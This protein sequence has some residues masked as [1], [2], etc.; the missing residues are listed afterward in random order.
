MSEPV[1][2]TISIE[3]KDVL[4]TY[5]IFYGPRLR[6]SAE[7]DIHMVENIEATQVCRFWLLVAVRENKNVHIY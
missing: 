2:I 1:K 5:P 4:H 6:Y 3:E 7:Q